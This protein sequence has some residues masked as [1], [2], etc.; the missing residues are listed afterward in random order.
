MWR[1]DATLC[2]NEMDGTKLWKAHISKIM[3]ELNQIADAD[4]V[5]G[6]IQRVTREEIMEAY[7]Y[8]KIGMA[9]GP[10]EVYAEMI[11]A[12]DDVGISVL[13][14]LCHR[15]LDGRGMSEDRATRVAIPSFEGKGDVVNCGMHR[16]V[17]QL[18]HAIKI[19]EEVFE[20]KKEFDKVNGNGE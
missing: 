11:L 19:V 9:S 15:I 20:N 6:P 5:E 14:E 3:N 18:E 17:K 1:N 2:L 10:T 16:G 13:M 12:S 8:L 4:T 7:K